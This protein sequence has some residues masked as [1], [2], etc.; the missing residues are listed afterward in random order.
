MTIIVQSMGIPSVEL[1]FRRRIY[2]EVHLLAKLFQN[3]ESNGSASLSQSWRVQGAVAITVWDFEQNKKPPRADQNNAV[4][5]VVPPAL[6][7][8]F[9]PVV[10]ESG[11]ILALPVLT[12]LNAAL[13]T[14]GIAKQQSNTKIIS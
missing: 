12:A 8:P 7:V 14:N 1:H 5:V 11:V 6:I 4:V 10:L 9:A 2:P 3:I 13:A